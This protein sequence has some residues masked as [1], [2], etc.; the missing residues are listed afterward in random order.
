MPQWLLEDQLGGKVVFLSFFSDGIFITNLHALI[1]VGW[2][3]S[4]RRL[5]HSIFHNQP[6]FQKTIPPV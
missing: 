6:Q 3:G 1:I 5:G 4:Y 2:W